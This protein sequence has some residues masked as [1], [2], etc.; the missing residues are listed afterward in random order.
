MKDTLSVFDT[1]LMTH[2]IADSET[3]RLL[4]LPL[5]ALQNSHGAF[6]NIFIYAMKR[7]SKALNF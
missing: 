2:H 7:L 3:K 5:N 1:C 6:R 4:K